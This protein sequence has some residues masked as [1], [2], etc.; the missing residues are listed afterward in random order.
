MIPLEEPKI[1]LSLPVNDV[2]KPIQAQKKDIVCS[3]IFNILQLGDHEELRQ[4]SKGLQPDAKA[5]EK[6]N[7][8]E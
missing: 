4:N 1:T 8:V 6:I 2:E 3:N 7:G 5:P